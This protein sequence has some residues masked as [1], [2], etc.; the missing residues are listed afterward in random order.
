[1]EWGMGELFPK[2]VEQP[3]GNICGCSHPAHLDAQ[4]LGTCAASSPAGSA[5]L[6]R[7]GEDA[8]RPGTACP[9]AGPAQKWDSHPCAWAGSAL[10]HVPHG[11]GQP[12]EQPAT[13]TTGGGTTTYSQQ[14]CPGEH[15]WRTSNPSPRGPRAPSSSWGPGLT[16]AWEESV[17]GTRV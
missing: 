7:P 5:A 14:Q 9:T 12:Q 8:A 4:E 2:V 17:E 13:L 1:M 10:C 6:P 15:D 16:P 11:S 3:V